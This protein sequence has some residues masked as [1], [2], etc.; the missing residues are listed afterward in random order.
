[1]R[2]AETDHGG[3]GL[4]Y[5]EICNLFE[6]GSALGDKLASKPDGQAVALVEE[7]MR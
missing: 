1:M 5:A 4:L 3:F 7:A 6:S 2:D